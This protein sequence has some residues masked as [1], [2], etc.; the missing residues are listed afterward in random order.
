[1]ISI[2]KIFSCYPKNQIRKKSDIKLCTNFI[3]QCDTVY[4]GKKEKKEQKINPELIAVQNR[5]NELYLKSVELKKEAVR[6]D[7]KAQKQIENFDSLKQHVKTII[8][9]TGQRKNIQTPYEIRITQDE[10]IIS[11]KDELIKINKSNEWEY[12]KNYKTNKQG[13][14]TSAKIYIAKEANK[15]NYIYA[16]NYKGKNPHGIEAKETFR[17]I[18]SNYGFIDY[19]NGNIRATF[20]PRNKQISDFKKGNEYIGLHTPNKNYMYSIQNENTNEDISVHA[21]GTLP[22]G[23]TIIQNNTPRSFVYKNKEWQ[24]C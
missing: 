7:K 24:K 9:Q 14:I 12:Y 2:N 21:G 6:T 11:F 23:Y 10:K 17:F 20:N 19:K 3:N 1:M 16:I 5:V 4:F 15:E 8:S 22:K 18:Y 13:E